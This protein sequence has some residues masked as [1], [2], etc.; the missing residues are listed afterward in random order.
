M[1]P[2]I[3]DGCRL[4]S[5]SF[6]QCTSVTK[7]TKILYQTAIDWLVLGHY[8]SSEPKYKYTSRPMAYAIGSMDRGTKDPKFFSTGGVDV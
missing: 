7:L 6:R 4:R 3:Q 5:I 1:S 2:L 8:T